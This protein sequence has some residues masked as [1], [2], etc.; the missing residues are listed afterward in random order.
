MTLSAGTV[1]SAKNSGGKTA[2]AFKPRGTSTDALVTDAALPPDRMVVNGAM[3]PS[4]N[5]TITIKQTIF[6]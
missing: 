1:C 3:P 4:T 6:S 2:D 5:K